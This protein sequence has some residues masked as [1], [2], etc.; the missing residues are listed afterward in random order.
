MACTSDVYREDFAG[1]EYCSQPHQACSSADCVA[2]ERLRERRQ[3][4]RIQVVEQSHHGKR[5][6]GDSDR[7][8]LALGRLRSYDALEASHLTERCSGS[9]K[10]LGEIASRITGDAK[11]SDGGV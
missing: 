6:H 3:K 10:G 4:A 7:L 11:S 1:D 5:H 2:L 8:R 9:L